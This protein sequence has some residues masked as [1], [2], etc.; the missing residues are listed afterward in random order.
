MRFR[1]FKTI[2]QLTFVSVLLLSAMVG[3]HLIKSFSAHSGIINVPKDYLTIQAAINAANTGDTINVSS[4]TYPEHV[5][6]NK[7]VSLIGENRS[8]TII[9][10]GG[11][12]K[13]VYVV[14]D[15]VKVSG[16]TIRDGLYGIYL[17]SS[18]N[19]INGNVVSD[20]NLG[21]YVNHHGNNI[22]SNNIVTS[23]IPYP[24]N[25]YMGIIGIIIDT[26]D[27]NTLSQNVVLDNYDGIS[28]GYSKNNTLRENVMT[29]NAYNFYLGGGTL[30]DFIHDIDTS[31]TVEGKP[32]Y[33]LVNKSNM[34]IP[35][36]AGCVFAVNSTNITLK[37]L[38]LIN[39]KAG[40]F[41]IYTTNSTIENVTLSNNYYGVYLW[42]SENNTINSNIITFYR[43]HAPEI[44]SWPYGLVIWVSNFNVITGN[45]IYT[46]K[47]GTGLHLGTSNNNTIYHNN[48][49]DNKEQAWQHATNTWDNGT[50]G[51]YWSDYNGTDLNG[52]G[53]GDTN[54]P[55]QGVDYYPLMNPWGSL[56]QFSHPGNISKYQ[57]H[58]EVN[59]YLLRGYYLL[60]E[61]YSYSEIYEGNVTVWYGTT[62]ADV[63]LSM[64]VTHPQGKHIE[65][66]YLVLRDI[67]MNKIQTVTS[68][69]MTRRV[70]IA[71]LG[72][73]DYAW[74]IPDNRSII[75]C[76]M[77]NI[78]MLW[79][80][81]PP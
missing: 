6:L 15:D 62:P 63:V 67:D 25:C 4:G 34:Q 41:L 7:T 50:E 76:E 12:G 66:A 2:V 48:F 78:D 18:N 77:S 30:S 43:E 68:F 21:I 49:I 27:N 36:D 35:M 8:T 20:Y 23:N 39:N 79:P 19:V 37:D 74:A 31:N 54:L 17:A 55:W 71:R 70:L 53:I 56:C 69:T 42:H 10:G 72:Y 33:Y 51:N 75:F 1:L 29:R 16:F 61:F 80:Y 44:H 38:N 22:I 3:T 24:Y 9:D 46:D 5:V 28:I 13:V 58:L 57:V 59:T 40:V 47:C 14:A 26:S 52:D 45:T 73:L 11:S 81:A 60:T 64:D 65:K 32:I